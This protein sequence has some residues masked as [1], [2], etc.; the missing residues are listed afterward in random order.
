MKEYTIL[1]I[2]ASLLAIYFDRKAETNLLKNKLFLVFL[3]II[4][5]LKLIVNG[6]LTAH[7]VRYNPDFYLGI[8]IFTIPLEDFFFGFSMIMCACIIWEKLKGKS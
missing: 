1:V 3:A 2:L 5:I 4:F 7:I 6:F 8:R